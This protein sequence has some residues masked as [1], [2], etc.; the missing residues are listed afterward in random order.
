MKLGGFL[1][2]T[3]SCR[4]L[5]NDGLSGDINQ[6]AFA[7]A[8]FAMILIQLACSVVENHDLVPGGL[9]FC[10]VD[11]QGKTC[12]LLLTT[13]AEP[14][15]TTKPALQLDLLDFGALVSVGVAGSS[16]SGL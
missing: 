12:D 8:A 1:H 11:C 7:N 5:T 13:G 10:V 2:T 4:L 15:I 16:C 9:S 14:W 6:P 3:S